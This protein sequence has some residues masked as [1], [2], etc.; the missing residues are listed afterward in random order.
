MVTGFALMRRVIPVQG[1]RGRQFL[2]PAW[3]GGGLL[4]EVQ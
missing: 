4:V 3:R 2:G 1:F